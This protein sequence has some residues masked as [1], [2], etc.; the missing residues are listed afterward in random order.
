MQNRFVAVAGAVAVAVGVVGCSSSSPSEPKQPPGS[1]PPGTAQVQIDGKDA[2]RTIHVKCGQ[3]VWSMFIDIGD[4]KSGAQVAFNTDR[5]FTATSVQITDMAGF[6][7]SFQEGIQ[8]DAKVS[9]LGSTYKITGT[10]A[11]FTQDA[12]DKNVTKPFQILANC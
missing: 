2:G 3:V 10:A 4:K 7:G 11:G 6:T 8:G 1:L 9:T 12:P 5:S